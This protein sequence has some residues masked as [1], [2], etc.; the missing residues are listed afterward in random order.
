VDDGINW[1]RSAGVTAVPTFIFDDQYGVVGAQP[2]E[3]L[4][5]VMQRMGKVAR[6]T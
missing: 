6:A 1:S 3:V 4:D 5:S 2:F